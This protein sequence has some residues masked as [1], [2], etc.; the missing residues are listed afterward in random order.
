MVLAPL[1]ERLLAIAQSFK[2]QQVTPPLILQP[3]SPFNLHSIAVGAH[4]A[5]DG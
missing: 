5:R 4:A 3:H 1:H 2:Q